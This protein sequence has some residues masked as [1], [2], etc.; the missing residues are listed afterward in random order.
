[1][2]IPIL[3]CSVNDSCYYEHIRHLPGP[4]GRELYDL[5]LRVYVRIVLTSQG[6]RKRKKGFDY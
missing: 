4:Y 5:E 2:I 6:N 3:E 1:M